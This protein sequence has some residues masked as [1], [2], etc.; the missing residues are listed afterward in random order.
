MSPV[1]AVAL[2]CLAGVLPA[3]LAGQ[4]WLDG[5]PVSWT[6]GFY[7]L[8]LAATTTMAVVLTT[9]QRWHRGTD[10][11]VAAAAAACLSLG[12]MPGPA[13]LDVI[14]LSLDRATA[15]LGQ[16][17]LVSQI[18]VTVGLCL[19]YVPLLVGGW[20]LLH[21]VT[22]RVL[23]QLVPYEPQRRL[24]FDPHVLGLGAV[25]TAG[26]S[27]LVA[28]S[29]V[30]ALPGLLPSILANFG[31]VPTSHLVFSFVST[32]GM[33][34]GTV[35][36]TGWALWFGT[37]WLRRALG[38]SLPR[39]QRNLVVGLL[40][41]WVLASAR[42]VTNLMNGTLSGAVEAL[43]SNAKLPLILGSSTVVVGMVLVAGFRRTTTPY[44]PLRVGWT[45]D[46][47]LLGGTI[48]AWLVIWT[49]Y[50][51]L[52]A[53]LGPVAT[54]I[55]LSEG[56]P[57]EAVESMVSATGVIDNTWARMSLLFFRPLRD[58][59]WLELL[60]ILSAGVASRRR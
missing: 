7:A 1:R 48:T 20:A 50:G 6:A 45:V 15:R 19:V 41:V 18:L 46:G 40:L 36:I 34:V 55:P 16:D 44:R 14:E 28:I 54:I 25:I 21:A 42:L 10:A 4:A 59:W 13:T 5:T 38:P 30:A 11:R 9:W 27:T 2:T 37:G 56:T 29:V 47:I 12:T 53:A 33:L 52:A 17:V 35:L 49:V 24:P 23:L 26:P 43:P 8:S 57:V 3:W 31:E 32:A 51:G 60:A 39:E 58:L 22:A